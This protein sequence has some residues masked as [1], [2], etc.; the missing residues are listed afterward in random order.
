MNTNKHQSGPWS[1]CRKI[2]DVPYLVILAGLHL[3][4]VVG[5]THVVYEWSGACM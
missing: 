2:C 1:N 5:Y 4:K 3:Y